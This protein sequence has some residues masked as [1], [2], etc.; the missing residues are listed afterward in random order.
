VAD[1]GTGMLSGVDSPTHGGFLYMM[2]FDLSSMERR[3]LYHDRCRGLLLD[4]C[5]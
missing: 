4:G 5:M 2:G 3:E 1:R